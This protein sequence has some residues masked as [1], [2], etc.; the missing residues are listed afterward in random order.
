MEQTTMGFYYVWC[1]VNYEAM[2]KDIMDKL[3]AEWPNSDPYIAKLQ[4]DTWVV[5]YKRDKKYGETRCVAALPH[6]RNLEDFRCS[7]EGSLLEDGRWWCKQHAPSTIKA[8]TA[9]KGV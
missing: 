1:N 8:K 2:A 6:D 5:Y 3:V 4:D 7:R 9:R